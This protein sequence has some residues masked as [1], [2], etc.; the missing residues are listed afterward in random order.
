M[1][2]NNPLPVVIPLIARKNDEHPIIRPNQYSLI[3]KPIQCP[4]AEPTTK[5]NSSR[6]IRKQKVVIAQPKVPKQQNKNPR[7]KINRQNDPCFLTGYRGEAFVYEMLLKESK[8]NK[9][10]WNALSNNQENP[11]VV[12]ASGNTYYIK[13]DGLHY[14]LYAEDD[15]NVKYYFEVKSTNSDEKKVQLSN[16]QIELA[17]SLSNPDEYHYVAVVLN[18]DKSPSVIYYRKVAYISD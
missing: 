5:P 3:N 1:S 7:G 16:C 17:K 6:F 18:A 4:I 2:I 14:D 13:E 11:Y 15:E 9:V 10:V 12:A 8:F